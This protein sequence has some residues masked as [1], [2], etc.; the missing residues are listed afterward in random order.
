M[1]TV[2]KVEALSKVYGNK[3]LFEDIFFQINEGE[4]FALIAE[5]GA[6]KTSLLNI[7][8]GKDIS[9]NGTAELNSKIVTAYLEQDP[10][11]PDSCSVMEYVFRSSDSMS[12]TVKQY[13][14]AMLSGNTDMI[15]KA[16]HQMDVMNAWEFEREIKTVL[17][18]LK[19]TELSKPVN[20]LSG[21]Q[22][23]RLAL[24]VV[25]LS[26]PQFM[27]LD[28]PTN[29]LDFEMIE[30]L[31]DY[32]SKSSLTVFTVSHDRFFLD[33]VCRVFLEIDQAKVF[34]YKGNYD[35]FERKRAERIEAETNAIN[36]A[37]NLLKVEADWMGRSPQ[38]R[39]TK[40]KYRIDNYYKIKEEA[41]KKVTDRSFELDIEGKRLGKKIIELYDIS[42]SFGGRKLIDNF[43]FMFNHTD[44]IAVIGKNG[45]GKSTLLNVV[46]GELQTDSGRIETGET[47][48]VGYYRQSAVNLP[49]DKRLIEVITDIAEVV[50]LGKNKELT[51]SAFANYF[52]FPRHMQSNYVSQLSGGEKKRLYLLTVLMKNPNILLL[53]EPTNDLDIFTLNVLEDYLKQF[54]GTVM[55]VSHDRYFIDHVAETL[56]V[57]NGDG[58]IKIFPGN[59]SQYREYATRNIVKP[60][61]QKKK[62]AG[63]EKVKQNRSDK[64]SYKEK[65]E[66]EKL[67]KEIKLLSAEK[68]DLELYMNSGN[69]EVEELNMKSA[70]L[71]ELNV[72]LDE[73]EMRWLELSE[74]I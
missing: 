47:V 14:L 21:G 12:E 55:F 32:L 68:H 63:D 70:R 72:L 38:A 36:A 26:R 28:E 71:N 17:D 66:F 46:A 41:E 52:M 4:K 30:W 5:N 6:G 8:T 20:E 1:I 45:V 19:I 51:A 43:S 25:L 73:M 61:V 35:H 9:D 54:K 60:E 37:K 59:Y 24:A 23:K 15:Q 39:T 44:R 33:K 10:T 62:E 69:Y 2:L 11:F 50:K 65:I 16:V 40:A 27:I 3:T 7:I 58:D 34:K 13:E 64:L 48:S 31:E 57:F 29:H 18:K 56:F 42:K 53:D 74:K 22:R 49:D 67:D